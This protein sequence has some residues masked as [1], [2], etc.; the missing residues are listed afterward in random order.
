[1][2]LDNWAY[3]KFSVD[4]SGDS[5]SALEKMMQRSGG[6][7][8]GIKHQVGTLRRIGGVAE[9][10]LVADATMARWAEA[11]HAKRLALQAVSLAAREDIAPARRKPMNG[12]MGFEDV[13][14]PRVK[15]VYFQYQGKQHAFNVPTSIANALGRTT[16][17]TGEV[18]NKAAAHFVSLQAQALTTANLGFSLRNPFRDLA[19]ASKLLPGGWYLPIIGKPELGW[20]VIANLGPA[21]RRAKGVYDPKVARAL[22]RH[23]LVAGGS[24]DA[25][26]VYGDADTL[27]TALKDSGITSPVAAANAGL[28]AVEWAW[29]QWSRLTMALQLSETAVKLAS[30]EY[31][32]AKFPKMPEHVKQRMV[33]RF[34]G[35]PDVLEG[36]HLGRSHSARTVM[37]FYNINKEAVLNHVE[38]WKE[39]P[40]EQS[41]RTAVGALPAIA[42]TAATFNLFSRFLL[43]LAEYF[44]DPDDDDDVEANAGLKVWA[45]QVQDWED[46]QKSIPFRDRMLYNSVAYAWD[47]KAERKVAYVRFMDDPINGAIRAGVLGSI[48]SV[49]GQRSMLDVL[50]LGIGDQTPNLSPLATAV[51]GLLS[52]KDVAFGFRDIVSDPDAVNSAAG[53]KNNVKEYAKWMYNNATGGT[54]GLYRFQPSPDPYATPPGT[55]EKILKMPGISLASSFVRVS[56][57]GVKEQYRLEDAMLKGVQY[58]NRLAVDEK[59][60]AD[61]EGR[62]MDPEAERII[63]AMPGDVLMQMIRQRKTKEGMSEALTIDQRR[64]ADTASRAKYGLP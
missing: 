22:E 11:Q 44:D 18:A 47:N 26:S 50:D 10:T 64:E 34:G 5:G 60:A 7:G 1:M 39:R 36:S 8:G 33:H 59:L 31:L 43:E 40:I 14:S 32:D 2:L 62:E 3:G 42:T 19:A 51:I 49:A 21:Y 12:R 13:D 46:M 48:E 27:S 24:Y 29:R 45:E 57:A 23:M 54:L 6:M 30:M 28:R 55:W 52:G 63:S 4:K 9:N 17:G 15:T 61:K 41:W 25:M 37:L 35:T 58:D 20:R 38:S 16:E 53:R 56:N